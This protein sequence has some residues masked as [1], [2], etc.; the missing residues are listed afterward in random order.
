MSNAIRSGIPAGAAHPTPAYGPTNAVEPWG[1]SRTA[2]LA[3][4]VD[5]HLR[6]GA[7]AAGI[8][9]CSRRSR[10]ETA[11]ETS[12]SPPQVNEPPS[13]RPI[14]GRVTATIFESSMMS[15]DTREVVSKT[16]DL[17]PRSTLDHLLEA[18]C[19]RIDL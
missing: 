1:H 5:L 4:T 11:W 15:D 16:R 13:A 14:A 10:R 12:I 18:R 19:A 2:T 3:K 9:A 8:G 7:H 6:R 17:D